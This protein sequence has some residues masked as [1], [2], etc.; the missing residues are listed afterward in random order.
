MDVI[1]KNVG[2]VQ[3]SVHH[4]GQTVDQ[5][6][7]RQL[8]DIQQQASKVAIQLAHS[9]AIQRKMDALEQQLLEQRGALTTQASTMECLEPS[10]TAAGTHQEKKMEWV[11][12]Q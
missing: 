7:K 10:V 11:K 4:I 3:G 2:A 6:I 1:T 9:G 12:Q 5:C 8:E